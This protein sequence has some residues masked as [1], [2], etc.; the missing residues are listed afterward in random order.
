[1]PPNFV[2]DEMPS[3]TGDGHLEVVREMQ[4]LGSIVAQWP[5]MKNGEG[6]FQSLPLSL[7]QAYRMVRLWARANGILGPDL[8]Y[9]DSMTL[10]W[11]A[12]SAYG[13][14]LE[15]GNGEE[16]DSSAVQQLMSSMLKQA[17]RES[18]GSTNGGAQ[19]PNIQASTGRCLTN[20]MS[21]EGIVQ[22]DYV[23]HDAEPCRSIMHYQDD[24]ED[25]IS[26]Y[27]NE[28]WNNFVRE[29]GAYI[30]VQR[31]TWGQ[32]PGSLDLY[33]SRARQV[34]LAIA[35]ELT[36]RRRLP[37]TNPRQF[38]HRPRIWP[39]LLLEKDGSRD[40]ETYAIGLGQAIAAQS[41]LKVVN[42][43]IIDAERGALQNCPKADG[44]ESA[45]NILAEF[46]WRL[47]SFLPESTVKQTADTSDVA[48]GPQTLGA[49]LGPSSRFRTASQA[50]SRLRHD[51]AHYGIEYDLAYEDRFA[52]L[53]WMPLEEWG[54]KATEEED[55]IPEHRV[56]LMKRRSDGHVVWDRAG[57][58]DRT[59]G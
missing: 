58:F 39:E 45:A 17:F 54:G 23:L 18:A 44:T 15:A 3:A 31:R 7:A 5:L 12:F 34:A 48:G 46:D 6:F 56:R 47:D 52:G 25:D 30:L 9:F 20:H 2:V 43:V 40:V 24:S 53:V 29:N 1:M 49:V 14:L 51:P 35:A 41:Q 21:S 33:R 10:L 8:G 36:S 19:K 4:S 22:I 59:G 32:T 42:N 27:L 26:K 13:D 50:I 37:E 28:G 38:T 16:N 55:F 11:V 57:R